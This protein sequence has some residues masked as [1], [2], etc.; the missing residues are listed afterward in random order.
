MIVI[1]EDKIRQVQQVL[2]KLPE[3]VGRRV[4]SY[5]VRKSL[6]PTLSTAQALARVR[7]GRLQYALGIKTKTYKKTLTAVG[8]VG[9][10]KL[11]GIDRKGKRW[12]PWRYAHLVEFGTIRR[13]VRGATLATRLGLTKRTR[14]KLVKIRGTAG[15]Y[16]S[17]ARA[18]P[19][20]RP[21]WRTTGATVIDRLADHIAK[22]INREAA[23]L[24]K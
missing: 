22:G 16:Q 18:Y 21:A 3:D 19:F 1:S 4:L 24:A 20:L 17:G 13:G 15:R 5:G 9:A 6:M 23:K 10:Q 12:A 11:E 14:D 8:L 2:R 7:T